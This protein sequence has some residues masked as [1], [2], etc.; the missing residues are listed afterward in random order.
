[1]NPTVCVSA[2]LGAGGVQEIVELDLTENEAAALAEA[3]TA[4]KGK[5]AELYELELD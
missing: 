4:V 2:R 3:A 5:V 1:M